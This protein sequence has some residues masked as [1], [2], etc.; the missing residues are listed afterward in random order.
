[1]NWSEKLISGAASVNGEIHCQSIASMGIK[2]LNTFIRK[3]AGSCAQ[4]VHLRKLANKKIVVDASIYLYRFLS[5]ASL[6]ENM[7]LMCSIFRHYNIHPLFVFDGGSSPLKKQTLHDRKTR[8]SK[9]KEMYDRYRAIL[10]KTTDPKEREEI[11]DQMKAL[12]KQFIKV[13]EKHINT[14]KALLDAYGMKWIR[15]PGEADGL[16]AALVIRGIAYA[17]FSEDTDLFVYGCPRV[18]KYLSLINHTAMMY[19]LSR[20]CSD[21]SVNFTDFRA[22]C[23]LSGTD[24]NKVKHNIFYFYRLFKLYDESNST[25]FLEWVHGKYITLQQYLDAKAIVEIYD[26]HEQPALKT[27]KWPCIRNGRIDKYTLKNILQSDGF[28]FP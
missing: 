24:Y 15:A 2:L 19:D 8:K 4:E 25:N 17:C 14:V 6:V 28:I 12:R 5:E 10:N 21:L 18:L 13:D 23:V 26:T 3:M 11:T 9:A 1:M 22:L 16:C 27:V 20:I 7:Y